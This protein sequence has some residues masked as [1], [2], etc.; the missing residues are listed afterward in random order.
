MLWKNV[1]CG[2]SFESSWAHPF[3]I[4]TL[5]EF[6]SPEIKLN[7]FHVH[8][9]QTSQQGLNRLPYL[10]NCWFN[11]TAFRCSVTTPALQYNRVDYG[12]RNW[13]YS[14]PTIEWWLGWDTYTV[15]VHQTTNR[16]N[17]LVKQTA[18]TTRRSTRQIELPLNIHHHKWMDQNVIRSGAASTPSH[19]Q[20]LGSNLSTCATVK[21]PFIRPQ[22][23][24]PHTRLLVTR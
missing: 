14:P 15:H 3:Y 9:L 16:S 1:L 19:P 11:R 18:G 8:A 20:Y 22:R 23:R 12:D 4:S 6:R 2:R 10:D 7:S 21:N 5:R 24:A 13:R 17:G